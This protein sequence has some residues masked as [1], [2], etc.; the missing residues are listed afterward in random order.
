MI[1]EVFDFPK[2]NHH[3]T[4]LFIGGNHNKLS[5]KSKDNYANFVAGKK[6]KINIDY[7]VYVPGY[8]MVGFC[9]KV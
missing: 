3:I 7:F 6:L 9:S 5:K 8:I 1:D 2:D 4:S